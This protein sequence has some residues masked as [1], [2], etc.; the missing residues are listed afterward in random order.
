MEA[1][2]ELALQLTEIKYKYGKDRRAIEKELN[3]SPNYIDQI[4]SKGG[5]LKFLEKLKEYA[6][7]LAEMAEENKTEEAP[8]SYKS[9]TKLTVDILWNQIPQ[10]W[11]CDYVTHAVGTHMQPLIQNN[12]LVGGKRLEDLSFLVF[13][14]I[15]I[16]RAYNGIETIRYVFPDPAGGEGLLLLGSKDNTPQT[17]IMRASLIQVFKARFVINPL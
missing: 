16:L 10:Y 17:L 14:E 13:G 6:N 4:I 12:A 8:K 1:K 9:I 11:D 5:S 3:Y 2:K 7:R 15:Y